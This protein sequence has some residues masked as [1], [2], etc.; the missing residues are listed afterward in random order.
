VK[1]KSK[2][3]GS[4]KRKKPVKKAKPKSVLYKKKSGKDTLPKPFPVVGFGASAGGV[5]AF[6]T[7]LKNLR[8]DLGMAYVLV[9]HLSPNH[10]SALKEIMQ[11]KTIMPVQTVKDGMEVKV[12]NV[13]VIPPNTFMSIVDGHLKLAPRSIA[14]VGNFAVDYFLTA[15]ASIYKNNAIGV[16]LSGTATDGTL[17]LKAIKAFGGI[18]FAQDETAEFSGMPHNA[19]ASGYADL[20][21]SPQGIAEELSKLVKIPYAIL[22]PDKIEAVQL[23]ELNEHEEQLKI[24]LSLVKNK[25]GIDFF[26]QY[27]RASI[28]RRV[29]RRMTLNKLED[30]H[31]YAM[32]LKAQ[33]KE[34]DDLYNDFL[35]NV[36]TFFRDPDF[37]SILAN[38]VFPNLIKRTKAT[39]PIRI[40]VAGCSTGEEAYSIAISLIEYLEKRQLTTPIQIFASDLDKEAVEKARPGI[41]PVSALQGISHDYLQKYFIKAE[42]HYQIVKS[43]RELIVFSQHNLL[44]DP[45]FSRMDLISCQNVLI[46][47]E[48]EPQ[49]RI[50]QMVH[51]ALKPAGY[52]FL[53]KSETL[54]TLHELFEPLDKKIKLFGRKERRGSPLD[55]L[56]YSIRTNTGR[57]NQRI[58]EHSDSEKGMNKLML[59][60]YVY[61]GVV[62]NQN[63]VITQFFGDTSA[64]IISG[65]GK[66]SFNILKMIRQDLLIE[67]RSLLQVV[68]QTEQLG[69]KENILIYNN[70]KPQQVTLEVA[71]KKIGGYQFFLL[72]FK[73][74][75]SMDS[76]L[77]SGKPKKSSTVANRIIGKL[78][79]ELTQSRE[80]IRTTNEEYETTYEELQA[81]NEEILSSNEELQSVNEELE[82]SKEELQSANEELITINEELEKRNLELK[83]SQGYALAIIET[84]HNPL[85]VLTANL[86]VRM[87]NDAFYQTFKLIHEE[88][89][90]RFIYDLGNNSW[91][92]PALRENLNDLL[93]NKR[94][95]RNF[96]VTHLFQG[97]G[98]LV[99][100]IN[101]Y[102]LIKGVNSNEMLILLDFNN[103]SELLKSNKALVRANEMLEELAFIS[104]HDLQ[105]PLRKIQVFSNMLTNPDAQLNEY[106][107]RYTDKICTSAERMSNLLKDLLEFSVLIKNGPLKLV[108]INLNDVLKNIL[109]D[110]ELVIEREK[111]IMKVSPLPVIFGIPVQIN[112]LFYNL[113]GNALKFSNQNP[114]VSVSSREVTPFDFLSFRALKKNIKYVCIKV[115]DEG[116]GFD[117]QYAEKI[118][119]LFQRLNDLKT[120]EGTGV[121]LAIC[122][123]IIEDHHGLIYAE[124]KEGKGAT[125]TLF[126]PMYDYFT[127]NGVGF[128]V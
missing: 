21:R 23:K 1:N 57:E 25:K 12:N 6:A 11:T 22:P 122:K 123:K 38:E 104:S 53:G 56:P 44:K 124:G 42:S 7:L 39:D 63:M 109:I 72:I 77:Q 112:Q 52:L 46:Y 3:S 49:K 16:I 34:I 82:T 43:V 86:Q 40:W 127:E 73:A 84:M 97:L 9:M 65:P 28:Y 29:I 4:Q 27:K 99:L 61:P 125:F 31:E 24:I 79:E 117:Q 70:G 66:A 96:E 14:T 106:A 94:N 19:F 58:E 88:V 126:F 85:L 87:G 20:M 78:E 41:Y 108:K 48:A 120:V 54:R 71:P 30:L 8:P 80:I 111:A 35:I 13:Y 55:L 116:I 47:L 75:E 102:R 91:Q 105:E 59:T 110:Y 121:G 36:T 100:E 83:E 32:L 33:P 69:S 90:G 113:I 115:K 67:V 60:H 18:T 74:T 26:S 103:I 114:T 10:K 92:I 118:F 107:Q 101:A 81:T 68:R 76:I 89:E 37:F 95:F 64:Y 5:K 50:L 98:E 2:S 93:L 45:P 51:Y 17:G 128:P 119:V 62:L 15:L